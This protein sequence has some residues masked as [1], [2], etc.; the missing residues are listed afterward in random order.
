MEKEGFLQIMET[1][2]DCASKAIQ[3]VP[4]KEILVIK[5]GI[6]IIGRFSLKELREG[7][8]FIVDVPAGSRSIQV[9][10]R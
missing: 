6:S 7:S 8:Y 10:F 1:A 4:D 3:S 9:K 5:D 2:Y